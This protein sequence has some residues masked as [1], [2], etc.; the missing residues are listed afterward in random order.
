MPQSLMDI[1]GFLNPNI[2]HYFANYSRFVFN[3]FGDRVWIFKCSQ[4]N[5]IL[6]QKM[7]YFERTNKHGKQI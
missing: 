3:R 7:G 4:K 2:K 6:G 1:G 5:K